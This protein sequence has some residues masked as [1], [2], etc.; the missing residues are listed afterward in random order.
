MRPD[1]VVV[2]VPTYNERENLPHMSAAVLLH[3]YRLLI[4]DDSS[5][6]GTGDI[7]DELAIAAPGMEVLHRPRKEGLGRAYADGFD[8]AL[9]GP[10]EVVVQMDCD[11]SHNPSDL[12]RLLSALDG[13]ADVVLGSRYIPGGA[14][15]DWTPGR[16]L[17]SRGGNLYART[18]LGLRVRDATGGFR[19]WRASALRAMP[20][21]SVE[22]S[23]Y[24]FQVEMAM[25]A[26]DLGLAMVEVPIVFRDRTRGYSKMGSDIVL[27]A[28]R[29]VT[30]WGI[31]RR[32]GRTG[33]RE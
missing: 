2:V 28:M 25:R 33:P 16:K 20:Y 22:A 12:P 18:L 11:F 26:Q 23:G 9:S 15:P 24:G 19:A 32:L 5:P 10:V 1:D 27:E 13:G 31:A 3:G 6:D 29:L 21:R 30:R 4:V 7:A 14:T 17:L 8:R